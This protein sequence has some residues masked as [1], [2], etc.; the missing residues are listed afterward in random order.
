MIASQINAEIVRVLYFLDHL[1]EVRLLMNSKLPKLQAYFLF[2]VVCLTMLVA[3]NN[4]NNSASS[5]IDP[6][7]S[8]ETPLPPIEPT[9]TAEPSATPEPDLTTELMAYYPFDGDANDASGNDNHGTIHGATLTTDRFG[10][11]DSAYH[12]DGEDDYIEVP[13]AKPLDLTFAASISV[14]L[15]YEP[16]PTQDFYT[17]LEKSDP[18]RGGHSRYG[19][20]IRN[21]IAEFCVQPADINMPQRCLDS[22]IPL[23]PQQ[24]HHIVGTSDGGTLRI[25]IDGE[26]AGEREFPRSAI[27]QNTFELFIGTDLYSDGVV[28]TTGALDEIR[29]YKRALSEE[30]ILMLFEGEDICYKLRKGEICQKEKIE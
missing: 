5:N 22:E 11:A 17:I 15:L 16:Q 7:S 19:M 21:D 9:P 30:E 20:W 1:T 10:K 29:I 6:D 13:D 27:S 28:Y 2:I 8:T 4:A 23:E 12:F 25:Y 18:E 14:W 26:F 3:C 24:W